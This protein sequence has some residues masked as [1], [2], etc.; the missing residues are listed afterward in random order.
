[1]YCIAY[2]GGCYGKFI[3]WTL[4][5]LDGQYA[6]SDR[7]FT[8]RN[9]SHGWNAPWKNDIEEAIANPVQGCLVHPIQNPEDTF[10]KSVNKLLK[11]YDKVIAPYAD[12]SDFAWHLNNKQKKIYKEGWI[13]RNLPTFVDLAQWGDNQPWQIREFLSI[14]LLDTNI[15]ETGYNELTKLK[16]DKV[17]PLQIN[18]LRDDFVNTFKVICDW[19]CIEPKRSD[20]AITKLEQDWLKNEPFLYKDK[21]IDTLVDAIINGKD[22]TM[23]DCSFI[24]EIEIQRR[25]RVKGYEIECHNLNTW[26]STTLALRELIHEVKI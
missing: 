16:N 10:N 11:V 21:L 8:Y 19:L 22:K 23:A 26:P 20:D 18:M 9:T 1:M 7:P 12:R 13:N 15:S 25:L 17:L 6:D 3:G 14:N 5:W 4:K 24:D 2:P